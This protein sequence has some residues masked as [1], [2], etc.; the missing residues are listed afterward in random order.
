MVVSL[1]QTSRI[2][3]VVILVPFISYFTSTSSGHKSSQGAVQP[4]FTQAINLPNFL[5][6]VAAIAIVYFIMAKINFPTK[7]MLA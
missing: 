6:L 2:I 5:I 1:T 7:Q 3:L 4:H